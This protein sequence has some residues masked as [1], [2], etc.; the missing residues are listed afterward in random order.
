MLLA[1]DWSRGFMAN[2]AVPMLA[3]FLAALVVVMGYLYERRTRRRDD[4]RTLFSDALEA[5]AE[6]QEL[7]YLVLRRGEASPMKRSELSARI[8]AVQTRLDFFS[9]RL[10][11]ESPDLG[12]HYSDLV[13]TVRSESGSQITE[14][15][16]TK[17]VVD[18]ADIPLGAALSRSKGEA[19]KTNCLRVM[20]EHLE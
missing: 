6:Y 15:W 4:L 18:D 8:S 3:A 14:A 17:R 13:R 20:K 9:A 12:A 7:P 16:R 2:V 5:V 1:A 19:S 11:L 10:F